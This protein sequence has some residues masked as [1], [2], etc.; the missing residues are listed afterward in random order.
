MSSFLRDY[1]ILTQNNE[2]PKSF[3]LYAS[4]VALSSIVSSRVWLD[5]GLFTIRPNLYVILTGEPG[6]KK[7]T[8]M[9]IAKRLLRELGDQVPL[10][11]E[12]QTKEALVQSMGESQKL[13]TVEKDQ[14]PAHFKPI[15]D[16]NSKFQY[17]PMSVFVTELS[18]FVGSSNAGHMLDFLTTIYDEEMFVNATKGKGV[19]TLPMPYLTLLGCTVP[20]WITSKLK[21]DVISGGFS[22]RAIFVYEQRA[23]DATGKPL[24]IALPSV[25]KEMEDA[26]ERVVAKAKRLLHLKGPYAWGTRAKE[27]YVTWYETLKEPEDP[28]LSGWFNSVHVQMLKIAMLISASEWETG[29]PTLDIVHMKTSIKLL[30][31]IEK[32]IP[33]VFKGV[34]RNELFGIGNKL[35]EILESTQ[36]GLVSERFVK[37]QLFREAD[38]SEI[39]K[40][41]GHLV[42][43]RQIKRVMA[44]TTGSAEPHLQLI[45]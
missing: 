36:D 42:A 5:L 19:D 12:C 20:A 27:F 34:G 24:R 6:V 4:L 7:T 21:D 23:E 43:T 33:K 39:A 1:E 8:A 45:R 28:L 44:K 26:W 17:T 32:N 18:Q 40:I 41:I 37:T 3:H 11:A 30:D 13:C 35:L 16:D 9:S 14:V 15:D 31:L 25:N 38:I 29:V 2:V 22:R 10:S